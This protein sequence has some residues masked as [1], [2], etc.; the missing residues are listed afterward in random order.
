MAIA[1]EQEIGRIIRHRRWMIGMTQQQL[2]SRIGVSVDEV[3]QFESG[4]RPI[5]SGAISQIADSIDM[6]VAALRY[7]GG[8]WIGGLVLSK[9]E[10]AALVRNYVGLRATQMLSTAELEGRA[11]GCA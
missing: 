5:G 6:P 11:S 10:A 8:G 2:A 9:N 3:Q 7:G 1:A 4:A